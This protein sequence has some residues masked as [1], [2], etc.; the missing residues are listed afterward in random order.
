[1]T[2]PSMTDGQVLNRPVF[3]SLHC[4]HTSSCIRPYVERPKYEVGLLSSP[5]FRRCKMS[6]KHSSFSSRPVSLLILRD[7]G[8]NAHAIAATTSDKHIA[9]VT[10]DL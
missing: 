7:D 10:D 8:E 9:L 1:M 6:T 4:K 3:H 5:P 2:F